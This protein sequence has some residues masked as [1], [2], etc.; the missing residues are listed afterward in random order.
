MSVASALAW[1]RGSFKR[2]GS[3]RP[4]EIVP[5]PSRYFGPGVITQPTHQTLLAESIG[6]P[7]TATR[8][9]ANRI[10]GL[11]PQVLVTRRIHRGTCEDEILDRHPLK[12]LLDMPHPQFSRSKLLRLTAQW[13][14]T[15]GEAY[16]QKVGNGIGVPIEL[17]PIP[18]TF[19]QP[20]TERNI[21]RAY[22][23]TDANGSQYAIPANQM[24]RI[25][26]PDPE[27]PWRSE[28]TLGPA[29]IT[30]DSHKFAGQHLRVHYQN[31]ATPRTILKAL[32][33]DAE[34]LPDD[35]TRDRFYAL[36][37]EYYSSRGGTRSGLPAMLPK[38]WDAM[39][40]AMQTGADLTPLLEYW[41]D[42]LLMA[43]GVP[44]SVLG[45]VVSGDRSSAETNQWVFDRYAVKPITDLIAEDLT[46]QLAKDF[47]EAIKVEFEPFVS[48]DKEYELKRKAQD[49]TMMVTTIN[50]ERVKYGEEEVPWGDQPI[51]TTADVPYDPEA[52]AE[53]ANRPPTPP[54]GSPSNGMETEDLDEDAESEE[55]VNRA[56][57]NQRAQ[58]QAH[59]RL[60]QR[61]KAKRKAQHAA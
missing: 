11:N 6:I 40:L 3:S 18:P 8:A 4:I 29:G 17:H 37:R 45:Q 35:P 39:E 49:L 12:R 24:V 7:D 26:W 54:P 2:A 19:V 10:A 47:D 44:R 30:A 43:Y 60:R 58:W 27:N 53:R 9:I 34:P 50:E 33:E 1:L 36:W 13:V 16:W 41:R 46:Y 5:G 42:D 52:A 21:T 31:D 28:G 25:F 20:L 51:G 14:L 48:E 57:S 61:I 55:E 38:G 56:A 22:Q 32:A 23:I 59:A 15:T